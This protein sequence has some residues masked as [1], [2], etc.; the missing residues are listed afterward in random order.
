M[1][2]RLFSRYQHNLRKRP[3]TTNLLSS[4]TIFVVGDLLAQYFFP[5]QPVA[6]DDPKHQQKVALA[7]PDQF[8]FDYL[9]CAR[10]FVYGGV[11]FSPIGYHWYRFIAGVSSPVKVANRTLQT[12]LNN[13]TRVFVDQAMF[14]PIAVLMYFSLMSMLELRSYDE[15]KQKLRDN[16]WATLKTNWLVW[17]LFQSFNFT[18]VPLEFRLLSSNILAIFWNCYLSYLNSS[19]LEAERVPVY[20]PPVL[21]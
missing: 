13:T 8:Q 3:Y 19:K 14:S 6:S 1:F 5:N 12:V 9:R 15:I 2:K 16:Y 17:P 11:I 10:A 7:K 4:G 20:S 18:V 21:E